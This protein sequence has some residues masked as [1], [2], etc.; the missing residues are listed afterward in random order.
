MLLRSCP[1]A[2]TAD[3]NERAELYMRMG[4]FREAADCAIQLKDGDLLGTVRSKCRH[5]T[6]QCFMAMRG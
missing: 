4:S 1:N 6:R 3:L 2:S 5:P